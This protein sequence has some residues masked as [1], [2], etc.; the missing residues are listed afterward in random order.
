MRVKTVNVMFIILFMAMLILPLAFIDLYG[1]AVSEKENRYLAARPPMSYA[2][3]WPSDFIRQFDGWFADN[4]GFR[5]KLINSYSL[6]Q[7][8]ENNVQYTDGSNVMLIGE[9]GHHYYAHING[10]MISKYQGKPFVSDEQ[11]QGLT[12]GLNSVN[13]YL[14]E[15]GIPFIVMFCTDKESIYPE[16]YPK[17]IKRGSEPIQLDIITA[18][19]IENT[20]IDVFNIRERLLAEKERYLSYNKTGSMGELTHYNEIGAFFAYQELM[21]YINF[22]FPE[23]VPYTIDDI[24]ITY[25]EREIPHI[26][27]KYE[28]LYKQL[29]TDFFDDV[30]IIRPFTTANSAFE[31]NNLDLPT[32][33][34]LKDSYTQGGELRM[35][36]FIP[37]HFGKTILIHYTNIEYFYEY[38][39]H[40]RP[41]IVVFESAERELGIFADYVSTLQDIG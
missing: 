23:L 29:D 14:D 19:L 34:M 37:Q 41:D 30:E 26:S 35:A 17:S 3:Q 18:F 11:L 16:Y 40:Y 7:K 6:A 12:N 36:K 21:W 1:G 28:F 38:V 27:T 9:Q 33:L 4:V 10:W 20:D 32:I 39:D 2:F 5:D 25:D 13:R 31:N 15:K 8:L 24:M 22:Y